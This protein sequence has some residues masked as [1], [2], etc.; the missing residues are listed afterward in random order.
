MAFDEQTAVLAVDFQNGI[1]AP[2]E[3]RVH[4]AE[5]ILERA[6]ALLN[7]ARLAGVP[8]FHFQDDAGPGLWA[9]DTPEWEI[10]HRVSPADP[11]LVLRKKF[12]DAFRGTPLDDELRRLHVSHLV[13]LGAMTDFSIRATLQRALLRGYRVTLV[14]DA[15]STLDEFDAPAVEHVRV[16]NDEVRASAARSLPVQLKPAAAFF[17]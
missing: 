9:P 6:A 11:A 10:H 4:A 3:H 5:D 17:D 1:F 7:A 14:E 13:I 12:G 2:G 16:L 8:T 15:H